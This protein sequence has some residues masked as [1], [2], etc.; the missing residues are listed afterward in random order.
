VE[1]VQ[2]ASLSRRIAGTLLAASLVLASCGPVQPGKKPP[3]YRHAG[4]VGQVMDLGYDEVRIQ[5]SMDDVALTF[6]RVQ[7]LDDTTADGGTANMVGTIEDITFKLA[8]A[9]RGQP[10]PVDVKVDLTEEDANMNQRGVFSRNV[11][12]DPRTTFPR[13]IR[14]E[15]YLNRAI[16]DDAGIPADFVG[17]DFHVTFENGIEAASGRTVFGNFNAKVMQ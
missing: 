6:V 4:S 7:E 11:R 3:K 12:N 9:L 1:V 17:G 13:M 10:Q 15:L 16:V 14:G 8:M 5:S 2:V